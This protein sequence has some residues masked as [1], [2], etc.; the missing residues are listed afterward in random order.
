M[1]TAC[2][3][4]TI[5]EATMWRMNDMFTILFQLEIMYTF[6]VLLLNVSLALPLT[7]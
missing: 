4:L 1:N 2:S 6:I 3:Y 7:N 5:Y